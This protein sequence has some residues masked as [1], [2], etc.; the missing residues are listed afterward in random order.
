MSKLP[1]EVSAN[2]T[3][4]G[5]IRDAR[6][7]YDGNHD[8]L[9][10]DRQ[11]KYLTL[12]TGK[13]FNDNYCP[14][15]VDSLAERLS[16]TGFIVE[17]DKELLEAKEE[18]ENTIVQGE[19]FQEWWRIN[20]MD[21][22]QGDQ[23]VSAVRDSDSYLI[24]GWDNELEIPTFDI[25]L[26]YDGDEGVEVVYST[27]KRN[28]PMYAFKRWKVEDGE[29]VN[30]Y[31]PEKIEKYEK[32]NKGAVGKA[33]ANV[34]GGKETGWNL[35]E[36]EP[37]TRNGE[38]GGEGAEPLGVPVVHFKNLG[39]GYNYGR[40]E[41]RDVV[42][43]Q[44]ALNKSIIDM[45]AAADTTAFRIYTMVGIDVE[46]VDVYPGV[47]LSTTKPKSEADIGHIPGEDLTKLIDIKDSYA[48]EIARVS[49][50]PLSF[51]QITREVAAEGTLK[52][53]E[54][55]LVSR[56]KNRQVAFGNSW[57][58]AMIM[59]RKLANT[60]GE[61]KLDDSKKISTTWRDPETRN[62]KTQIE[63]YGTKHEKLGIPVTKIWAE[64]G[65]SLEQIKEMENTPEFRLWLYPPEFWQGASHAVAAGYSLEG[66]LRFYGWE[67]EDLKD[68]G[69][70]KMAEINARQE[71]VV[72]VVEQ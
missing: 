2:E 58:D 7:Y 55:G 27:E 67:D 28:I 30:I 70:Q 52:Q 4:H 33:I 23:H 66:Y 54:A 38:E 59:A 15:V 16:V 29:R 71:D 20:R 3:R 63:I 17:G 13:E 40:S 35:I 56:A 9:L 18:D 45:L 14:I 22:G 1:K 19:V 47:I 26:A 72:P 41:L 50:T 37:W 10:N 21:E 57:E 25:E 31:Y 65:Y 5:N 39:Q 24:V 60:F 42:P 53:E 61:M 34:T 6:E 51:F 36:T 46:D 69:T 12:K 8:T 62:D 44:N 68:I 43:L 48:F 49:R 11:K 32:K 64:E